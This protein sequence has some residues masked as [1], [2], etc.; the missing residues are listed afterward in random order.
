MSH[1]P[2]TSFVFAPQ[3]TL[4]AYTDTYFV[5]QLCATFNV[6]IGEIGK[7][8]IESFSEEHPVLLS[9]LKHAHT[10]TEKIGYDQK[11]K[12]ILTAVEKTLNNLSRGIYKDDVI[13][14]IKSRNQPIAKLQLL[15]QKFHELRSED[16]VE[17]AHLASEYH[18]L[19]LVSFF[20]SYYSKNDEAFKFLS[21]EQLLSL[22]Y[23]ISTEANY[24]L[25][26]DY[27]SLLRK[28]EMPIKYFTKIIDRITWKSMQHNDL[29]LAKKLSTIKEF[30]SLD[31]GDYGALAGYAVHYQRKEMVMRYLKM[32]RDR[33]APNEDFKPVIHRGIQAAFDNDSNALEMIKLLTDL[34]EFKDLHLDF[35]THLMTRA[36]E[37]G[38]VSIVQHFMPF[39]RG[40]H[41]VQEEQSKVVYQF[42]KKAA[43]GGHVE[44]ME[45]FKI[46]PETQGLDQK[47]ITALLKSAFMA[48][49]SH[50][51]HHFVSFYENSNSFKENARL[52]LLH[53]LYQATESGSLQMLKMI[54]HDAKTTIR[55]EDLI[56]LIEFSARSNSHHTLTYLISL[57]ANYH[58]TKNDIKKVVIAALMSPELDDQL[59][60][61]EIVQKQALLDAFTPSDFYDFITEVVLLKDNDEF[62]SYND[63]YKPLLGYLLAKPQAKE[64]TREQLNQLLVKAQ[65]RFHL[66]KD[67]A[68]IDTLNR[69][70]QEK[71]EL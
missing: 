41:L 40:Y 68:I 6:E 45:Y 63:G 52:S 43:E 4:C 53:D 24:P 9:Q 54:S 62:L 20:I 2:V 47:K 17:L 37:K 22:V 59:K 58:P 49:Q 71:E 32:L 38:D 33:K 8:I 26:E 19:D 18:C 27:L 13:D 5:N 60:S 69:L 70:I 57:N 35:F 61:I 67:K 16:V 48:K 31:R 39:F 50:M 66:H 11:T 14:T 36:A 3:E 30:S 12:A 10:V 23:P 44:L 15:S 28:N 29:A 51:A 46:I 55:K 7:N 25:I 65:E 64:I 1:F 21:T 56:D 42:M 34:P